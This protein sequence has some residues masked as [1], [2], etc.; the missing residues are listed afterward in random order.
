MLKNKIVDIKSVDVLYAH[1][2]YDTQYTYLCSFFVYLLLQDL[3][4]KEDKYKL[5]E[6]VC[7]VGD[8]ISIEKNV[9][10]RENEKTYKLV[11]AKLIDKKLKN[12]S[13]FEK[14]IIMLLFR[15]KDNI[16]KNEKFIKNLNIMLEREYRK[17]NFKNIFVKLDFSI[18]IDQVFSEDDTEKIIEK[19]KQLLPYIYYRKEY[20]D[21]IKKIKNRVDAKEI[22]K[23]I[24]KEYFDNIDIINYLTKGNENT[25]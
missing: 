15:Y 23:G 18:N 24:K 12:F 7:Y 1:S 5:N 6:I 11:D 8:N 4:E 3:I 20:N 2:K 21:L 22:Y 13:Y 14:S 25:W 19:C 9:W 16:F 10:I 17:I